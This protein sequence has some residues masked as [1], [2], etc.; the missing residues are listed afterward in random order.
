MKPVGNPPA[1]PKTRI[2]PASRDH[3]VVPSELSL[4][5]SAIIRATM[6]TAI[7]PSLTDDDGS[8]GRSQLR[9][10]PNQR[11]SAAFSVESEVTITPERYSRSLS[12]DSRGS[13]QHHDDVGAARKPTRLAGLVGLFTGCGALVA[14]SL[15]LPLPTKFGD[16][17]GVTPGQAVAYS[18]YVVGAVS[19]VIA[20]FVF[21]G[22]RN[23][24]GEE[25]KGWKLL[26][27]IA[28]RDQAT[29]SEVVGAAG[30]RRKVSADQSASCLDMYASSELT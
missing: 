27:G 21:V 16:V 4:T 7:L 11:L 3:F 12:N 26:L 23:L 24:Q 25:D 29:R 22:L 17:D 18:F 6:V 1:P 2:K 9:Y 14:L 5:R 28:G 30:A 10:K 15:F 13:R 8:D 19:L 20:I